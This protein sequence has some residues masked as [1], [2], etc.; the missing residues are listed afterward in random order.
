MATCIHHRGL[1]PAR[2][3]ILELESLLGRGTIGTTHQ[4][5][6]Q[7]D[8]QEWYERRQSH[9]R[10]ENAA[11]TLRQVQCDPIRER[12]AHSQSDDGSDGRC[13][14][15]EADGASAPV[16]GSISE[17]R[18]LEEDEQEEGIGRAGHCPSGPANDRV[19]EELHWGPEVAPDVLQS[20][21]VEVLE[22]SKLLAAGLSVSESLIH[23]DYNLAFVTFYSGHVVFLVFRGCLRKLL[24]LVR[25]HLWRSRRF[26]SDIA[27]FGEGDNQ[28]NHV[29][30]LGNRA[31]P[32]EPTPRDL[33]R[34]ITIR[35]L[36]AP[37]GRLD[38]HEQP[39]FRQ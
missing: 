5:G 39:Y 36:G 26:I 1:A 15:G 13:E 2:K 3:S 7:R 8:D 28:A 9:L 18:R 19:E 14:I 30:G 16:V 22:E 29:D 37:L 12:T 31:D 33:S 21:S 20:L 17:D 10:F 35:L 24:R 27:S 32:K 6:D 4:Q 23:A 25:R 34:A 11:I 38:L